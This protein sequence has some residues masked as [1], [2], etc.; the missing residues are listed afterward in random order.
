V[1]QAAQSSFEQPIQPARDTQS[2][3]VKP[4]LS[5]LDSVIFYG[6]FG[7]LLFGPLA[8]GAVEPWSIFLL[9]GGTAL[10]FMLWVVRQVQRGELS[11]RGNP[12]FGPMAAFGVLI[13]VQLLFGIT[14]YRYVTASEA[15]LYAAYGMLSFL[16][17]Q[18]LRRTSQL[19]WLAVVLPAYGAGLA[20]FAL[21]QALSGTTKLYWTVTPRLGGWIY[22]PYVNH[23]HYAGL[24][25]MLVPIPLVLGLGHRRGTLK[26]LAV[27]A[28]ALMASTIFLS[29]SRGGMAAFIVELLVVAMIM[30]KGERHARTIIAMVVFLAVVIGLLIWLG[31]GELVQRVTSIHTEARSEISGGTRLAIDR[32]ALR[33]L[34][35]KPVLG[36]GLGAFPEIYPQYRSFY[37]NFFVNEAHNDYLQL[38]VET[39][40]LGFALMLWLIFVVYRSALRKLT[41]W[42]GDTNATL[43]LAAL[44]G[45]TG[46]LVH[47]LVDFNLQ[48]PANTALFYVLCAVAASAP[49]FGQFQRRTR[50]RMHDPLAVPPPKNVFQ[51]LLERALG[52]T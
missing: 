10:L 11:I 51:R 38:L 21:V 14:A 4:V 47:S 17:V 13:A 19:K 22:G 16:V 45:V 52:D 27:A 26:I 28:A 1:T 6:I 2:V 44:L 33:M 9:E 41:I 23:N 24:M 18:N 34:T 3:A 32:D 5:G 50:E 29:G 20:L 31:G 15:M 25:E 35:K 42:P 46:I 7:L 12:V 39:G 43:A 48:I 30:V 36:W 49:A 40:A 8:F 37:T